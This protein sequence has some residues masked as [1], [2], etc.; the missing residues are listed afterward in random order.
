MWMPRAK[1]PECGTNAKSASTPEA[2]SCE[3]SDFRRM[4]VRERVVGIKVAVSLR[5]MRAGDGL[6]AG[7]GAAGDTGQE[8]ARFDQAE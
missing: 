8:E 4:P 1:G 2:A 5:M 6:P 3:R 7:A